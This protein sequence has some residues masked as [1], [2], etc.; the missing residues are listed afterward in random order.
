MAGSLEDG[1]FTPFV[2]TIHDAEVRIAGGVAQVIAPYKFVSDSG[3][4]ATGVDMWQLVLIEDR[5]RVTAI[6]YSHRATET[7]D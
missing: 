6:A 1:S 4:T 2:E 7:T 5:W 3:Y